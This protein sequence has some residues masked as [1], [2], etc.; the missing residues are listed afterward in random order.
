[1]IVRHNESATFDCAF[2]RLIV[3]IHFRY[4]LNELVSVATISELV[5]IPTRNVDCISNLYNNQSF[6]SLI[7]LFKLVLMFGCRI[8]FPDTML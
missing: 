4:Q 6:W 3:R 5:P 1:M 7:L 2:P 8:S